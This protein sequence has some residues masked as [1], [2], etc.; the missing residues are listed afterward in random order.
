MEIWAPGYRSAM[1]PAESHKCSIS[2]RNIQTQQEVTFKTGYQMKNCFFVIDKDNNVYIVNWNEWQFDLYHAGTSASENAVNKM[3]QL[4]NKLVNV[5]MNKDQFDFV[6]WLI[7][8]WALHNKMFRTVPKPDGKSRPVGEHP[9]I[10]SKH[11]PSLVCSMTNE[12]LNENENNYFFAEL[13]KLFTDSPQSPG[14]LQFNDQ[15]IISVAQAIR[16]KA[17][18]AGFP[19]FPAQSDTRIPSKLESTPQPAPKVA[20]QIK[21]AEQIIAVKLAEPKVAEQIEVADAKMHPAMIACA[22]VM[23]LKKTVKD[24]REKLALAEQQLVEAETTM[25]AAMA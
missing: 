3:W 8:V 10:S 18:T 16:A 23:R 25:T 24:L 12:F 6:C 22:E 5:D 14:Y 1:G 17:I 19:T 15:N 9:S 2:A 4:A 7:G 21:P 13:S 11:L 20:E